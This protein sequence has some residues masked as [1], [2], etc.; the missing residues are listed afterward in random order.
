MVGAWLPL[1]D[2]APTDYKQI[3]ATVKAQDPAKYLPSTYTADQIRGFMAQRDAIIDS[4]LTEKAGQIG[5]RGY[6]P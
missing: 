4:Y 3:V 5:M 1:K 6:N 2:L